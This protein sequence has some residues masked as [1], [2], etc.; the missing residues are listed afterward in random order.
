MEDRL[1]MAIIAALIVAEEDDPVKAKLV[2][3]KE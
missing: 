2:I 3:I 1:V